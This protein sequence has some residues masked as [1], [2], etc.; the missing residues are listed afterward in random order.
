MPPLA[1]ESVILSCSVT[2]GPIYLLFILNSAWYEGNWSP[3]SGRNTLSPV[4]G[5]VSKEKKKN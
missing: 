1:R 2:H 4:G 5:R 3:A